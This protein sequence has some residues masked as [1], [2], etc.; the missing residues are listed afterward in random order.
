MAPS[1]CRRHRARHNRIPYHNSLF[2]LFS[3]FFCPFVLYCFTSAVSSTRSKSRIHE[4]NNYLF[5]NHII[6]TVTIN[7][8]VYRMECIFTVYEHK[9]RNINVTFPCTCT[10]SLP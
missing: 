8:S 3:S 1:S 6:C 5:N 7:C 4:V 9:L 10:C 2:L